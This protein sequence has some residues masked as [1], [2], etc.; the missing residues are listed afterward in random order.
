VITH[1]CCY[2]YV[3]CFCAVYFGSEQEQD[4]AQEQLRRERE[5]RR[6]K[7][8]EDSLTL[9]QTK[10]QVQRFT[11]ISCFCIIR[12]LV[13]TLLELFLFIRHNICTINFKFILI[14]SRVIVRLGLRVRV[15]A[16]V[17]CGILLI[18]IIECNCIEW[19]APVNYNHP[20][21]VFAVFISLCSP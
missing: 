16:D 6:K 14:K 20:Y 9:E 19:I 2:Y 11:V 1:V 8:E 17:Y 21:V 7:E 10:E 18:I 15:F 5:L 13:F 4:K 12:G 3:S